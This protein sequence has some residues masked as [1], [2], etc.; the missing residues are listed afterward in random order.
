MTSIRRFV[1]RLSTF[2]RSGLA[3]IGLAREINS[4]LHLRLAAF[5]R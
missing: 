4:H 3:E 2:F 5:F 1:L